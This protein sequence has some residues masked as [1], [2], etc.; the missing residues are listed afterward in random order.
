[1]FKILL[2]TIFVISGLYADDFYDDIYDN[3]KISID[4]K[5][6][7]VNKK[8]LKIT[9]KKNIKYKKEIKKYRVMKSGIIIYDLQEA[10]KRA[11]A[12]NKKIV[13][14][15]YDDQCP[16]WR[17]FAKNLNNS[18][19]WFANYIKDNFVFSIMSIQNSQKFPQLRSTVSPTIYFLDKN[20]DLLTKP[21]EGDPIDS[22]YFRSFIIAV[23][24]N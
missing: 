18:Q 23:K 21:I 7:K 8:S 16:V 1:M 2:I 14:V 11:K 13:L 20:L 17:K 15:V 19:N 5:K 3:N 10:Q 4:I 9:K 24:Q 6:E 12:E 22:P